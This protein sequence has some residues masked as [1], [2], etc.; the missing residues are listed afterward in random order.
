MPVG[1]EDKFMEQSDMA[2]LQTILKQYGGTEE[3]TIHDLHKKVWDNA[4]GFD[5]TKWAV[6]MDFMDEMDS[7]YANEEPLAEWFHAWNLR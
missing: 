6:D 3:N 4:P 5:S 1:L 7:K 2:K